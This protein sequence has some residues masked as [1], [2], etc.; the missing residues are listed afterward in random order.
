[1]RILYVSYATWKSAVQT[2]SLAVYEKV[3]ATKRCTVWAGSQDLI[4]SADIADDTSHDDY[5]AAFPT[6]R[7]VVPSEDE[8]IA[9]ILLLPASLQRRTARGIPVTQSEM[10]EGTKADFISPNWCNCCTW[11]D[12][13]VSVTAEVLSTSNDLTFSSV[14]ENW[15]NVYH[16]KL[17]DE[18]KLTQY[19]VAVTVDDVAVIEVD[20]HTQAGDYTINH[21]AGTITFGEAQAPG[22][23]VK[24][25]FH[26][27]NGS[28][29]ILAP[30]PGKVLRIGV[31][32]VQFS[33]DFILTDTVLFQPY[34]YVD[35]FAPEQMPAIP[36]GT[37]I[38]LGVRKEYKTLLDYINDAEGAYPDIPQMGGTGWRALPDDMHVFRWPYK[39]RGS[40]DLRA[41]AGME[42]RISLEHDTPFGGS[43]ATA[44]FHAVSM[45]EVDYD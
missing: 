42:I 26:Y 6:G 41:S 44:T 39:E 19:R 11:Y 40:T 43:V 22:A 5:T 33:K 18:N 7:T 14:H 35:V 20:P 4:Y 2:H 27:E 38:P 3:H 1:M 24:A 15:I 32:E 31:V 30:V 23:V 17:S 25:T 13:A 36:P 12:Q 16:G 34:G 9:Q 29:W 28:E 8:A 45:D 10:P 21:T 37:K